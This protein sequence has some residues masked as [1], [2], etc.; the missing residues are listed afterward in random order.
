MD[1][2]DNKIAVVTGGGS[3]I[4]LGIAKALAAE[5]ANIVIA[6]I[7]KDA[8][9]KAAEILR[10][11]GVRSTAIETD[12]TQRESVDALA[13]AVQGE[14]GGL[15]ILINNA[16]V[17]LAGEMRDV[18]EDDWRFVLDVNL[19]GAFRVGQTFA[20]MLRDQG[21]GGHIVN[22]ASVGGFTVMPQGVTY[23]VS[24]FGVVAYS[25]ALRA[26]LE[27]VGIG[28]ST[29]CP[30]PI[31]TNLTKS[32]RLRKASD[33]VSGRSEALTPFIED[34]MAPDEIGPIVVR[35]IRAN[36]PYIFTHDFREIFKARFDKVLAGFDALEG[37]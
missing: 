7:D 21:R 20:G 26:D 6:D 19:D 23:G 22:T 14:F 12:V 35:G 25:E 31:A 17:Y 10:G 33:Q 30:G 24:K 27:P 32:D 8:A 5:G 15:D 13:A 16:G 28:V 9:G 2:F 36:A 34:G 18:T 3:G 37:S 4:G 29:L 11:N 1:D